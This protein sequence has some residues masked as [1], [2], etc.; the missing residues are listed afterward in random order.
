MLL[1][2]FR[3]FVLFSCFVLFSDAEILSRLAR[4]VALGL[5]AP[6]LPK[7]PPPPPPK[8]EGKETKPKGRKA[9]SSAAVVTNLPAL[10]VDPGGIPSLKK[11]VEVCEARQL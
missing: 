5:M 7:P 2:F 10:I 9:M 1:N 4:T 11:A 8:E 3:P 6:W